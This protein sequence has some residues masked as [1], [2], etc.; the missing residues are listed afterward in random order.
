V[1]HLVI[2]PVLLPLVAGSLLLLAARFGDA[3]RRAIGLAATLALLPL[4]VLLLDRVADGTHLVYAL[5]DWAPPFGIV[6]VA[7]RLAAVMLLLTA[8]VALASLVYAGAG[9]D[10]R[11]PQYHALFQFQLLGINGAFLTGDLFNLFV[12]FEVLL[13]ASYALL[14]HG[15]GAQR[16][17]AAIH[18]V[19]LNLIGSA[20]FLFAVGTLYA[21]TGTLNFADLA[22]V[23]PLLGPDVAPLARSGALLLL[24]VFA[25]KAALLPLGFWL[26]RA[27]AAATGATAALF[28]V[29]TKVGV[30]AILRVYPLVFGPGAGEVANVAAAWVLPVALVTLAFGALGVLAARTLRM[31][32]GWMVVYSVG[33][34]LAAVGLFSEAGYAAAVYYTA[35]STLASAALFLV[36]DLIARQRLVGGDR[37]EVVDAMPHGVVLGTLFFVTAVTIAGLPPLSGFIGKLFVL[38]AASAAPGAVVIWS[39]LL[40]AALVVIVAVARAGSA[41]F[42]RTAPATTS[43]RPAALDRRSVGAIASLLA[44][45]VGLVA[46]GG[47]ATSYAWETARQLADPAG[48][49][50]AVLGADEGAHE[51]RRSLR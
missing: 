51:Q 19:V 9:D 17:G 45:I 41:L 2:L 22:R 20:L 16:V 30:Y 24:G 15:L 23:L 12:F 33:T 40:V 36:S 6:L 47:A 7:D 4:A 10:T 49:V 42:W 46:W 44:C 3:A 11:G 38:E 1:T 14:L 37:F 8:I 25:L 43:A 26:P 18:V 27:Y 35:H 31:S 21:V 13:I 32:A 34:L 48:Y 50:G 39:V 29:L 5:G 28:A